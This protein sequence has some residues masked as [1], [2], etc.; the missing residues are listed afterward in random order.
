M[1]TV[2][3]KD[4]FHSIHNGANIKQDKSRSGIPITRIETIL[5]NEISF[6]RMGYAGIENDSYQNYYLQEGDILMSHINSI[7]HLGKVAI[8]EGNS[9][10]I[11]HGMNLLCLK[12]DKKNLYPKYAYYYFRSEQFRNSIKKITKKS[13]NQA[14]FNISSLE[15]ICIPI[16]DRMEDQIWIVNVLDKTELLIKQRKKSIRLLDEFLKSTFLE[17]FGEE[18]SLNFEIQKL[19]SICNKITDGEHGTVKRTESGRLYLMARN[20]ATNHQLDLTEISYISETDH[21]KIYKRCNA[22]KDDL[23]LVCVGATI[24]KTSLVPKMEEF[25]LARSVALI[26]P[27]RNVILSQYLLWFFNSTNGQKLLKASRN[28]AAQ[29]GLYTGKLKQLPIPVPSIYLQKRFA[30]I[31]EKCE[32]IK[33]LNQKSLKEI[34]TLYDSYIKNITCFSR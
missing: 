20:I 18:K 9:E 25:S 32:H 12:A 28:E 1:R 16:P 22:E 19:D 6:D 30:G 13:V 7:S 2:K 17:M 11:I 31:V 4:L 34:E 8:F 23:L 3:I 5:N 21:R 10:K 15:N 33:V 26:K 14:S 29:A 24:G 27:K